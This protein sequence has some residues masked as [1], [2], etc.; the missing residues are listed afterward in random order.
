MTTPTPTMKTNMKKAA[1]GVADRKAASVEAQYQRITKEVK[2]QPSNDNK[3]VGNT[4]ERDLCL[5]L[6]GYGFWAHNLAQNSQG[7]PFDV[8][9]ARNGKS[10]PIDCKVCEKNI[11]KM[12]RVEENQALAMMLWRETGNGEGWFALK[13]N[14]G[15]VFFLPFSLL[16]DLSVTK[17]L[18]SE[19]EIRRY[20]ITLG[21][22]VESC[23]S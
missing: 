17:H 9:A 1:L 19:S 5:S 11:F 2:M 14:N 23:V 20:G 4:F 12:E 3:R 10:H 15:E 7:Q 13:L 18:L 8:I 21:K 16:E 22:W 6:S